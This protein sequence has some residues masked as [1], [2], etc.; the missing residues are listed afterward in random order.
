MEVAPPTG[1]DEEIHDR[2][3]K[4]FKSED[5]KGKSVY[6][7]EEVWKQIGEEYDMSKEEARFTYDRVRWFRAKLLEP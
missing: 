7:V 6:S 2:V 3:V 5:R 4:L 1:R